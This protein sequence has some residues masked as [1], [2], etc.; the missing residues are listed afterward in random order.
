MAVK[1]NM[2]VGVQTWEQKID[3]V[4]QT[5][6]PYYSPLLCIG[7]IQSRTP[8]PQGSFTPGLFRVNPVIIERKTGVCTDA[9]LH[10]KSGPH[11]AGSSIPWYE[12]WIGG[13][14][15]SLY[16]RALPSTVWRQQ[17]ADWAIQEAYAKM[18]EPQ[19]NVALMLAEGAQTMR[20]LT[21]PLQALSKALNQIKIG[22]IRTGAAVGDVVGSYWLQWQLGVIPLMHDIQDIIDI[23]K[24][25]IRKNRNAFVR[26]KGG[27]RSSVESQ[28]FISARQY[29]PNFYFDVR[30]VVQETYKA[31]ACVYAQ[32]VEIED[33]RD[34]S[35]G[36]DPRQIP[37]L[38]WELVPYS[39]VVD[40]FMNVG[41]WI[42]AFT[43]LSNLSA[44]GNCV[45]LK[46]TTTM[47]ITGTSPFYPKEGGKILSTDCGKYTYTVEKLERRTNLNLPVLPAI[48]L[49]SL[50]LTRSVTAAALA[51]QQIPRKWKWRG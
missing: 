41:S 14:L 29:K 25:G 10:G 8:E 2:R 4:S 16:A 38:G 17:T 45:S 30:T 31:T 12:N 6:T 21:N 49:D 36:F 33:M 43:P 23:A 13:E 5:T 39:F 44:I 1:G 32:Q 3:G 50:S 48:S 7:Q 24:N 46:S 22:K 27:K 35:L 26:F 40:W 19:A 34:L 47:S 37:A 18:N 51:W 42:K 28:N 20:M 15:M 11:F 9:K